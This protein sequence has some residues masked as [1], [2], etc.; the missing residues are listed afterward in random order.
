MA[1]RPSYK[2]FVVERHVFAP[3]D[4]VWRALLEF[5]LEVTKGYTVPGDPPPHG[6]GAEVHFRLGEWD[7]VERTL[8]LEPPWRRVYEIIEGA[9]VKL[10]QATTALRD[11]GDEC[12]LVW[13]YLAE[14]HADGSS[15]DFLARARAAVTAAADMVVARVQ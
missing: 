3:R 9:P 15:D 10:Y 6:P 5:L 14:V 11:D 2:T 8:T 13:S 4:A 1:P 12:H 7:L